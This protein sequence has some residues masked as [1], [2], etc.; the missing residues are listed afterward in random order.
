VQPAAVAPSAMP[1]VPPRSGQFM[2]PVDGKIISGFGPKP[3]G[4]HNDGINIKA[5]RGTAV[6]AAENGVVAYTGSEMAGYGNLVLIR[7]EGRFIT[8]YAHLDKILVK[9]GDVVRAGQSIGT[10]G[11]SGQVDSPQLHFEIRKGTQALDPA[12][13]L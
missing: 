13:H 12:K 9:R 2:R 3:D 10:V 5:P 7:H 8:A 6:R 1:K 11:S 4:L